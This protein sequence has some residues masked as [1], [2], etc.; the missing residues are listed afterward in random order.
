MD[1]YR[2][3]EEESG[4]T[5]L[6]LNTRNKS[7][8][9]AYVALAISD[10]TL[11]DSEKLFMYGHAFGK[12]PTS[13]VLD[14]GPGSEYFVIDVGRMATN[15]WFDLLQKLLSRFPIAMKQTGFLALCNMLDVHSS[16][17]VKLH[18]LMRPGADV[19]LPCRRGIR[20]F[21]AWCT[22]EVIDAVL[23]VRTNTLCN[24][25]QFDALAELVNVA[26]RMGRTDFTAVIAAL[27]DYRCVFGF[28]TREPTRSYLAALEACGYHGHIPQQPIGPLSMHGVTLVQR[29][30]PVKY[31]RFV[32]KDNDGHVM[33]DHESDSQH[34]TTCSSV[35][36]CDALLNSRIGSMTM[37]T[38]Y[39]DYC[40]TNSEEY[41]LVGL[42]VGRDD[43]SSSWYLKAGFDAQIW[44]GRYY[45][46]GECDFVYKQRENLVMTM[47]LMDLAI[48][49]A[50][51]SP[52][53]I[54]IGSSLALYDAAM[55]KKSAA[56][57][58][59]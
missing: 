30:K 40:K 3:E 4:V 53:G 13:R 39:D 5:V 45:G 6:N 31:V 16:S 50:S 32:L 34:I 47:P 11:E 25:S 38:R 29:G 24:M 10:E 42:S 36:L 20:W 26:R 21:A 37:M 43:A 1:Q 46:M 28:D 19:S 2:I 57:Q 58:P 8:C 44:W 12:H 59:P 17:V 33:M 55:K 15:G 49:V 23:K 52:G 9:S 51:A 22:S 7:S 56:C 48:A 41:K 35:V 18:G 27:R 54:V 14:P